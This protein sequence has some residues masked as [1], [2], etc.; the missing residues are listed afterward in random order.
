MVVKPV[1]Q[2]FQ[3]WSLQDVILVLQTQ[4]KYLSPPRVLVDVHSLIISN[5]SFYYPRESHSRPC[6]PRPLLNNRSARKSGRGAY[7]VTAF[8]L[9]S[10]EHETL[11]SP[12]WQLLHLL[13][14]IQLTVI[15]YLPKLFFFFK[16]I[17]FSTF[18]HHLA[19]GIIITYVVLSTKTCFL[20]FIKLLC[21]FRVFFFTEGQKVTVQLKICSNNFHWKLK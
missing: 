9:S 17:Y 10:G 13:L 6:F 19:K 8:A 7:E 2:C 1:R 21:T 4:A 3:H 11:C 5:T 16:F 14:P 15:L 20:H 12:S 18:S